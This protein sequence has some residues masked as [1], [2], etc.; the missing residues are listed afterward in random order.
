[1]TYHYRR[2]K[3]LQDNIEQRILIEINYLKIP[4]YL[5]QT[6]ILLKVNALYY[7]SVNR[8]YFST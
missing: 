8:I 2:R 3:Y 6:N 4:C 1:M 7:P 5:R